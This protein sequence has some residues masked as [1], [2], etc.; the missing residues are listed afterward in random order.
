MIEDILTVQDDAVVTAECYRG[1][2]VV[3]PER[4]RNNPTRDG[5]SKVWTLR[6]GIAG[7]IQLA[8]GLLKEL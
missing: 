2:T 8:I 1:A 7:E 5:F 3:K 6:N 4:F